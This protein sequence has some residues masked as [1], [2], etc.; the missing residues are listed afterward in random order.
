MLQMP[1]TWG[2]IISGSFASKASGDLH[3]PVVTALFGFCCALAVAWPFT[4]TENMTAMKAVAFSLAH[5]AT[6]FF[7]SW[8]VTLAI[9]LDTQNRK[10]LS[11]TT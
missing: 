1:A 4:P 7:T 8:R 10:K 2:A 5:A 9:S 11:G 6:A 3:V